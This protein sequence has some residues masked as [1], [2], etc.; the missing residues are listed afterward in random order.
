MD[1]T[2][3]SPADPEM[4]YEADYLVTRIDSLGY[5]QGYAYGSLHLTWDEIARLIQ[6]PDVTQLT[7]APEL[8]WWG[9]NA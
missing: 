2:L 7:F 8:A 1:A 4:T 9:R 3:L 5:R 6:R